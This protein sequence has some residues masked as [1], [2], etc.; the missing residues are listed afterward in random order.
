[1]MTNVKWCLDRWGIAAHLLNLDSLLFVHEYGQLEHLVHKGG[2]HFLSD[3]L[4]HYLIYIAELEIAV[5][6]PANHIFHVSILL[7]GSVVGILVQ[8]ATGTVSLGLFLTKASVNHAAGFLGHVVRSVVYDK[9]LFA[10][11]LEVLG[12]RAPWFGEYG[13]FAFALCIVIHL[14][15]I[16]A[17]LVELVLADA[18]YDYSIDAMVRV[19]VT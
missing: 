11:L 19:A 15:M 9:Q 10:Y 13:L 16:S 8:A 3:Y 12:K 4:I 5:K 17:H 2:F 18:G 7:Y 14:M 1:M 6:C